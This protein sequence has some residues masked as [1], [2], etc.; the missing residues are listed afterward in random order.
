MTAMELGQE[1]KKRRNAHQWTLVELVERVE[2]LGARMDT[3]NLS[4]IERGKQ[5]C[6]DANLKAIATALGCSVTDLVSGAEAG[7]VQT[8]IGGRRIPLLDY[9]QAG[10]WTEAAGPFGNA[11]DWLLGDKEIS[12]SAFALKIR[13]DSMLPEFKEGDIVIVDASI[14]PLPGDFVVAKNERGEGTFKKF[15]PR[16]INDRGVQ[17]FEL[18]PLNTDYPSMRSDNEQIAI[19]GTMIEHRRY[20][21]K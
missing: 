15:R 2:R 5:G 9:V 10:R 4:R 17:V 11:D 20:R 12:T 6:S 3:G 14:E 18:V 16:G 21:R 13:G 8:P 1:I 19:V 7:E